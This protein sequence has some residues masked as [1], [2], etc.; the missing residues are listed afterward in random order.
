VLRPMALLAVLPADM[1]LHLAANALSRM[2][3]GLQ[4]RHSR[5]RSS[6]RHVHVRGRG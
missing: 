3:S 4:H 5:D 6:G 2:L 1:P